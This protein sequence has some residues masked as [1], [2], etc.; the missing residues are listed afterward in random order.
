ASNALMV[1]LAI[2]AGSAGAESLAPGLASRD[3]KATSLKG[4][5]RIDTRRFSLVQ[6]YATAL[7]GS[8]SQGI[9]PVGA[10]H[11]AFRQVAGVIISRASVMA[12]EL[13]VRCC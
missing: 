8:R 3:C 4:R 2:V 5:A 13:E 10:I 6:K 9:V 1:W 7:W 12:R 11:K